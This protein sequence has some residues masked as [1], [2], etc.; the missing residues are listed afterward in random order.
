MSLPQ[1]LIVDDDR[2]LRAMLRDALEDVPCEIVE[3]ESGD[4]AL[5]VF[6]K[7]AP[8]VMFLDL[9]MPGRSGLEV[10]KQLNGRHDA[11]ACHRA[12]EPRH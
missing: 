2:L 11:H 7:A 12:L 10:L 1:V 6:E 3:A 8:A 5:A 4:A 9:I